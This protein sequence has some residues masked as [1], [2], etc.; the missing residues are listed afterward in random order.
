MVYAN[1]FIAILAAI[2][3]TAFSFGLI[4]QSADANNDG[5]ATRVAHY[6]ACAVRLDSGVWFAA[7]RGSDEPPA[8]QHC[9]KTCHAAT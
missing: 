1:R 4:G 8:S 7:S 2:V 6:L 5:Q 9:G 3:M